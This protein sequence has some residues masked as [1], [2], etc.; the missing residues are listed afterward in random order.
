M[1]HSTLIGPIDNTPGSKASSP[2]EPQSKPQIDFQ[3]LNFSHPSEAKASNTRK[4]VR[5]HV[6]K[7]QHQREQAAAVARRTKGSSS[8]E[9]EVEDS[10]TPR[11]AMYP[12][13]QP[14]SLDLPPRAFGREGSMEGSSP[15]PSPSGST[16]PMQRFESQIEPSDIYPESWHTYL[17]RIMVSVLASRPVIHFC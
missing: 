13:N 1:Y 17:P 6:T 10:A 7:Q 5:S 4:A 12:S 16:S 14:M 11:V 8:A 2:K 15:S 3:F 9:A